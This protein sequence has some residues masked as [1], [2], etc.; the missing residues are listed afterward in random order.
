MLAQFGAN[1]VWTPLDV[2]KQRLQARHSPSRPPSR[3]AEPPL[4]T[5]AE[6]P[7]HD[8][9]SRPSLGRATRG[10]GTALSARACG[11]LPFIACRFA[12]RVSCASCVNAV[13]VLIPGSF[14]K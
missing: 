14:S 1:I 12:V 9:P 4:A 8:S 7:P 3:L 11:L 2:V 10:T 5:Q 6:P 13:G